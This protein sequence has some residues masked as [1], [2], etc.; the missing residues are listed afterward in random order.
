MLVCFFGSAD[1]PLEAAR[2]G[3]AGLVGRSYAGVRESRVW[4]GIRAT[5]EPLAPPVV[6]G[7]LVAAWVGVSGPGEGAGNADASLQVGLVAYSDGVNLL[8]VEVHAGRAYRYSELNQDVPVG[9]SVRVGV[10]QEWSRPGVWRAWVN[11]SPPRQ[12]S[13]C[14]VAATGVCHRHRGDVARQRHVP[15]FRLPLRPNHRHNRARQ[16]EDAAHRRR[17]FPG[18]GLPTRLRDAQHLP[19]LV[20]VATGAAPTR[21]VPIGCRRASLSVL[22]APSRGA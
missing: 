5:L 20:D 8:Y 4:H 9:E 21:P 14:A 19:R 16:Q 3:C 6:D 22:R 15:A 18:S 10:L 12:R 7:G 17:A 2:Y 1:R 11:G 13:S